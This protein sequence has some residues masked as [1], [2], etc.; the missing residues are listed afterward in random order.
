MEYCSHPTC[1]KSEEKT[2]L[3][4]E[5]TDHNERGWMAVCRKHVDVK[6]DGVTVLP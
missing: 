6:K 1:Y 5:P 3:Y 4:K 2:T